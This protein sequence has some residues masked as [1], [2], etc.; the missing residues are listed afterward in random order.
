MQSDKPRQPNR[1]WRNDAKPKERKSEA[2]R[3]WRREP[4]PTKTRPGLSRRAKLATVGLLILGLVGLTIWWIWFIRPVKPVYV[5]LI[6]T[7]Y[8]DNLAIPHNAYGMN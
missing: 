5:V 1:A 4:T 8:Y 3:A 7:D 2:Q 6:G